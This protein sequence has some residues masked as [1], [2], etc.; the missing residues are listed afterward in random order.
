M[1]AQRPNPGEAVIERGGHEWAVWHSTRN[2]AYLIKITQGSRPSSCMPCPTVVRAFNHQFALP[3]VRVL[4]RDDGFS[5]SEIAYA[6]S[7][8][9]RKIVQPTGYVFHPSG[10]ARPLNLTGM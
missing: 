3:H 9:K 10:R 6:K 5:R 2:K 1:H 7:E 8:I 4:H